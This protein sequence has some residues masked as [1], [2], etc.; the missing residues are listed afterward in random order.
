MQLIK[1]GAIRFTTLTKNVFALVGISKIV[2]ITVCYL[3]IFNNFN[4]FQ[5]ITGRCSRLREY[6]CGLSH[7]IIEKLKQADIELQ[8]G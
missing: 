3:V 4:T 8:H 2:L 1:N 6:A 5:S 7:D